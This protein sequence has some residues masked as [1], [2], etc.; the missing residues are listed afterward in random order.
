M[1]CIVKLGATAFGE[2]W[3]VEY[4]KNDLSSCSQFH[5]GT[6]AFTSAKPP[7]SALFGSG[8]KSWRKVQEEELF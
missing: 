2:P 4:F 7:T 1:T 8:G 5:L 3:L 6:L